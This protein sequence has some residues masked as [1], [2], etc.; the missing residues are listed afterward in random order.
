MYGIETDA[1]F[2]LS[3]EH[4]HT[5]AYILINKLPKKE[6]LFKSQHIK[7]HLFFSAFHTT[8]WHWRSVVES[9]KRSPGDATRVKMLCVCVG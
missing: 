8:P 4:M 7:T 5:K 6:Q 9:W 1:G 2:S 3:F